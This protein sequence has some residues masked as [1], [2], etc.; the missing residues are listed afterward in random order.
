[1]CHGGRVKAQTLRVHGKNEAHGEEVADHR[2]ED[3]PVIPPDLLLHEAPADESEPHEYHR[4][5]RHRGYDA[6]EP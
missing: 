1:M 4:E 3:K 2:H 5:G 6:Y